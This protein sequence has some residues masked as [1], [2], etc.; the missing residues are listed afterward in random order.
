VKMAGDPAVKEKLDSLAFVP[1]VGTRQEFAAFIR[2]EI[3]KWTKV[4]KDA[5]V[6]L[7]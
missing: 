1:A 2:A 4:A 3:A 7:E 6:K 5:G